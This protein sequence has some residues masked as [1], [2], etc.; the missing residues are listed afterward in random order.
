MADARLVALDGEHD[1]RA[2]DIPGGAEPVQMASLG[3]GVLLVRFPAGWA[4]PG[5][6]SYACAEEFTILTGALHMSRAIYAAPHWAY[7]PAGTLRTN[8]HVHDEVLA[9][10][11]FDGE[12]TWRDGDGDGTIRI[13]ENTPL[14]EARELRPGSTHLVEHLEP[15][16]AGVTVELLAV[17]QMRWAWVRAGEEL[18]VLDGPVIVRT[19]KE[20]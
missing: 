13:L 20:T 10:A 6:G 4:R 18:P 15:G 17:R 8:T 12:P 16:L 1:W 19:V 5:A 3:H 2:F 9:V 11:R 7:V 14:G